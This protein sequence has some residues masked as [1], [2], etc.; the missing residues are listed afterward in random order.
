M[1]LYPKMCTRLTFSKGEELEF[2]S[3]AL[4]Q[5]KFH[6]QM[7]LIPMLIIIF[8]TLLF[9]YSFIEGCNYYNVRSPPAHFRANLTLYN[10]A[11]HTS[12]RGCADDRALNYN[13]AATGLRHTTA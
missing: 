11:T 2:Y 13:P 9:T 1:L 12:S 4:G 10:S 8:D 7:V 3:R 5:L 6:G